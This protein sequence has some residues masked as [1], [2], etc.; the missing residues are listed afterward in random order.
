M[1]HSSVID[2]TKNDSR[3]DGWFKEGSNPE[4]I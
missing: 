1:T 2:R 3:V 4:W